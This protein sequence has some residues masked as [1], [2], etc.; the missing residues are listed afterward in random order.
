MQLKD[1][2]LGHDLTQANAVQWFQRME[3]LLRSVDCWKA[4]TDGTGD[5]SVKTNARLTISCNVG[6]EFIHIVSP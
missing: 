4:V 2:K 5:E 6:D 3:L 1:V